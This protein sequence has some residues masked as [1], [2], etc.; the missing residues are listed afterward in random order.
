MAQRETRAWDAQVADL[1]LTI[2]HQ[3][4]FETAAS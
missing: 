2:F 4:L 1:L 3:G